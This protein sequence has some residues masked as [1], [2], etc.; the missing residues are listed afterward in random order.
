MAEYV[1]KDKTNIIMKSVWC[2][3][4][5]IWIEATTKKAVIECNNYILYTYIVYIKLQTAEV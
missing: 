2:N 4:Y 1:N 3:Y 5:A